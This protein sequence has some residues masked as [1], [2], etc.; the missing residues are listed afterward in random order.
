M[1][2]SEVVMKVESRWGKLNQN[3]TKWVAERSLCSAVVLSSSQTSRRRRRCR[4]HRLFPAPVAAWRRNKVIT[5]EKSLFRSFFI[6]LVS[7][8]FFLFLFV[9][10]LFFI[11]IIFFSLS[12]SSYSLSRVRAHSDGKS[13]LRFEQILVTFPGEFTF[14]E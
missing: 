7:S 3:E 2:R 1:N 13:N 14:K 11:I 5:S 10:F 12:L 6:S 8:S 4:L 9:L